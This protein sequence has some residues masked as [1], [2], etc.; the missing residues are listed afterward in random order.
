[1][2]S[3]EESRSVPRDFTS[4]RVAASERPAGL[5]FFDGSD[6]MA[7]GFEG[8]RWRRGDSEV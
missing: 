4:S 8:S 1:M 3:L 5:R 7:R 6:G 2:C